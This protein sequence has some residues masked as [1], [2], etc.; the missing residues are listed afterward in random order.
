MKKASDNGNNS[1][2]ASVT[3]NCPDVKV[4]KVANPVGP[5]SAGDDIGFDVTLSNIGAGNAAGRLTA[6][7]ILCRQG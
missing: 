4:T 1:A 3:V 7:R 2:N 5:V 6:S